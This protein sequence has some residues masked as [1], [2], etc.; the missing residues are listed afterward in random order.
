VPPHPTRRTDGRISIFA[1]RGAAPVNI[2][3]NLLATSF[4]AE[5]D[6]TFAHL[7]LS[8]SQRGLADVLIDEM[9]D[10]IHRS[11][12]D[13]PSE[14][15]LTSEEN[16]KLSSQVV[17]PTKAAWWQARITV[18]SCCTM[19]V[20]LVFRAEDVHE[21]FTLLEPTAAKASS[22]TST[23]ESVFE[24]GNLF[25]TMDKIA[26]LAPW[27]SITLHLLLVCHALFLR[28]LQANLASLHRLSLLLRLASTT[29]FSCFIY[30]VGAAIQAASIHI[31]NPAREAS[32]VSNLNMA[33]CLLFRMC[34]P[35]FTCTARSARSPPPTSSA[36]S[37][38][39]FAR[40]RC[41]ADAASALLCHA[42][43][44]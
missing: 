32:G 31:A 12:S 15:S 26:S 40:A 36:R 33:A 38:T 7:L 28:A 2:L 23:S 35:D 29:A 37:P 30:C 21:Y 1:P 18:A 8:D 44:S 27:I 11:A 19:L 9:N 3:L 34:R 22:N 6:S 41:A 4:I 13:G 42:P 16:S 24:C 25:D 20:F 43:P 39:P 14:A 17:A 10:A 5:V